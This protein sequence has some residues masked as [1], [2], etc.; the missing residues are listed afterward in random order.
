MKKILGIF[1][2]IFLIGC[3]S[4]SGNK[5]NYILSGDYKKDITQLLPEGNSKVDIM[6]IKF[7]DGYEEL[8]ARLQR[9]VAVNQEWFFK[10]Q[11]EN[12]VP[13]KGLPYHENLGVTEQEWE[14]MKTMDS[15]IKLVKIAES[16]FMVERNGNEIK[17]SAPPDMDDLN[18]IRIKLDSNIIYM[19]KTKIS[20]VGLSD[21]TDTNNVIGK[22]K[23]HR[24]KLEENKNPD[25][26]SR[27]EIS[28]RIY[29]LTLGQS[30]KEKKTFLHL[31]KQTVLGGQ[32]VENKE[33]E[34]F[35][36]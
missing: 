22:W 3:N 12:Y 31:K 20:Y 8:V 9:S 11:K 5:A 21:I 2:S 34:V 36:K 18:G 4:N 29:E 19:S 28:G 23:G 25:Y 24:W 6:G 16:E 10:Y 15:Q 14:K 32:S 1:I 35:L 17:I 13:G 33:L 26:N 30:A 7:P 27:E